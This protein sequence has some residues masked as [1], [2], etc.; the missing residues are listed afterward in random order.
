[1]L[2]I[3]KNEFFFFLLFFMNNSMFGKTMENL[4]NRRQIDLVTSPGKL[5]KLVKQPS[6]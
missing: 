1:M 4:R 3:L 6:F 5:K 2:T